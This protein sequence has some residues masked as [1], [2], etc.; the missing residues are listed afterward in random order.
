MKI[1]D[2]EVIRTIQG[3]LSLYTC[4]SNLH[5]CLHIQVLNC[6]WC[7]LW[8]SYK[9]TL[10]DI[11]QQSQSKSI[12]YLHRYYIWQLVNNKSKWLLDIH[13]TSTL[14]N[15]DAS[16]GVLPIGVL[17]RYCRCNTILTS[18]TKWNQNNKKILNIRE[19]ITCANNFRLIKGSHRHMCSF[20]MSALFAITAQQQLLI[21]FIRSC[22]L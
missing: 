21:R 15:F 20:D 8:W 4:D 3:E 22:R 16:V 9:L 14:T 5:W 6:F 18:S 2:N 19:D 10:L 11:L 12:Q 13:C 1:L 7:K 17:L